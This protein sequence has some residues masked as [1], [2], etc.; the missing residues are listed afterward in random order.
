MDLISKTLELLQLEHD[1][2]I[3]ESLNN[4]SNCSIRELEK[5]GLCVTKLMICGCKTGLFGRVLVKLKKEFADLPQHKMSP[6]DIVGIFQEDI[7]DPEVNGTVYKVT[8]ST[9]TVA[10]EGMVDMQGKVAVVILANEATY[11]RQ[12]EI[13]EKL[14]NL[15]VNHPSYGLAEILLG[16]SQAKF[17][18]AEYPLEFSN[19]NLNSVQKHAVQFALNQCVNFGIIHGP[20]GTGKTTTVV[21]LILQAVKRGIQVLVTAPSNIAVDN[22]VEK[23]AGKA[24]IVRVGHPARMLP[25]ITEY[26]FDNLLKKTDAYQITQDIRKELNSLSKSPSSR[27]EARVLRKELKSRDGKAAEE[28]LQNSQVVLSTCISSGTKFMVEYAAKIKGF[29]LVIIDEAAQALECACWVPVLMGKKVVLAG[30]HKQL[31]PTIMS[32]QAAREGLQISMME[33]LCELYPNSAVLLEI[34]YRMNELIMNW[35]NKEFYFGRLIADDSVKNRVFDD[36]PY[37]LVLVDTSGGGVYDAGEISK[38]NSGE[39]EIVG[40]FCQELFEAGIKDVAVITP[41]NAQVE[42]IRGIVPR[43]E[44]SSVDGF[45]GREKDA[46]VISMVRSNSNQD[47]G[48]LQDF[49]RLNVAI[50]RAKMLVCLIMDCDTVGSKKSPAFLQHLCEYFSTNAH[51]LNFH[52]YYTG[53]ISYQ[54]KELIQ[55][56]AK[57]QERK[58]KQ[59]EKEKPKNQYITEQKLIKEPSKIIKDTYKETLEKIEI[60]KKSDEESFKT[61]KLNAKDRHS[62]HELCQKHNLYHKTLGSGKE[63]RMLISK[64][65]PKPG[66]KETVFI[67]TANYSEDDKEEEEEKNTQGPF[68]ATK[69]T[70]KKEKIIE[71]YDEDKFL[72]AAMADANKCMKEGCKSLIGVLKTVCK[73]CHGGF[74]IAHGL[75][76]VHGC[77]NRAH[78]ISLKERRMPT[79]PSEARV[80]A[81]KETMHQKIQSMN[82]RKPKD[83]KKKKK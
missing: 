36:F 11:K 54:S 62:I 4:R 9:I 65:F 32:E 30:D 66:Q 28:V 43:A 13:M 59:K 18:M 26:S 21:E 2:E 77:G 72:E 3:E 31:P 7:K 79:K 81:L 34:Q 73:Y 50:T 83:K 16:S 47:V 48:F 24:R 12:R 46:V 58:Q 6:G 61:E 53:G 17:T 82:N 15:N 67:Q 42:L 76:E 8:P 5:Q 80:N 37:P 40:K 23:L 25:T 10:C 49:R 70:Q 71:E 63:K 55:K 41:Y 56:Q 74:C 44:V 68:I 1:A 57:D 39:A 78:E 51:C 22:L 60:L 14:R 27:Q 20:P 19:P 64:I 52:E 35:S 38:F 69:I 29:G 75:A 33:R 45:Q